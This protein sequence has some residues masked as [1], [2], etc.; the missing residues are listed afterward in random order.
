MVNKICFL[1]VVLSACNNGNNAKLVMDYDLKCLT[2]ENQMFFVDKVKIFNS[3][4]KSLFELKL[5]SDEMGTNI[6]CLNSTNN[7]YQKKG[8]IE[9]VKGDTLE[10]H[11]EIEI[12]SKDKQRIQVYE[13]QFNYNDN[14]SKVIKPI[15]APFP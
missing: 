2:V 10:Q 3:Y 6:I 12:H 5:D 9:E 4:G 8:S 7:K 13:G 14:G 11:I 15:K 1:L